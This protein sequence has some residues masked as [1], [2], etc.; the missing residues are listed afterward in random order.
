MS[1]MTEMAADIQ[2]IVNES[3]TLFSY[4]GVTYT[5]QRSFAITGD[6]EMLMMGYRQKIDF[7]L[8]V[9][10]ANLGGV[11]PQPREEFI[12]PPPGQAGATVYKIVER[13]DNPVFIHFELKFAE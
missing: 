2:E 1:L 9:P 12:I 11:N 5:G 4:N 3:P 13:T 7:K 8:D 6:L 10:V